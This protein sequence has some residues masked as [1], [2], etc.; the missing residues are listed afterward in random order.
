[1]KEKL[2]QLKEAVYTPV[3][4][5]DCEGWRTAE[6]VP[7]TERMTGEHIKP[8]LGES[9][10]KLWDCAWMHFTGKA[11][12]SAKGE[13]LVFMIDIGGEGCLFDETGTPVR[14]ITNVT[15]EFS[16]ELGEPGKRIVQFKNPADGG[17]TADIWIEA[18]CNDLFG[19]YN[20]SGTIINKHIAVCRDD[21][22]DLYYDLDF[23]INFVENTAD[24]TRKEEAISCINA[25]F[26]ALDGEY[27][28]DSVKSARELTLAEL[29]KKNDEAL[30]VS[31]VGH[32]HMDLAWL[33]PIRETKRKCGR[34]FSTVLELMD[35]YPDYVFGI[36]Q[37][38][39]LKW[40]KEK[41]PVL[42]EKIKQ[43]A[44]EGRI[45]L[46]GGFWVECDANLTGAEA[47]VRQIIHGKRF[48]QE[49][50]GVKQEMLWLPDVFG[51]SAQIPQIMKKSGLKYFQTIKM[52]WNRVN[53]IPYHTFNWRSIDGS[54]VLV[55]MPPEGTY[56]SPASPWSLLKS[57][58]CFAEKAVSNDVLV[59]F[60]IGD[61][62]GGPGPDHLERVERAKD[63]R[64]LPKVHQAPAVDFFHKIDDSRDKY[65][66]W[67]GELYLEKHQGTY[68]TQSRN[69]RYN[70][71]MEQTL[72]DAEMLCA[73]ASRMGDFEYPKADFDRIWEEVMLYQFHDIIPGSSIKRVYDESV[74]RYKVLYEETR[75]IMALALAELEKHSAGSGYFNTL[76]CN[77]EELID[78]VKYTAAPFAFAAAETADGQVFAD[79]NTLENEYIKVVFGDGGEIKSVYDKELGREALRDVGNRLTVYEDDADAWEVPDDFAKNKS[80]RLQLADKK[81]VVSAGE[82]KLCFIYRHGDSVI[83]QDVIL[84]AGSRRLDFV[85]SADWQETHRMLRS[86]FPLTVVSNTA[87]CEIQFGNVKRPTHTN[88]SWEQAKIEVCA[89]KWVDISQRDYGVALL[90]NCKYGYRV[91]NNTIDINLLRSSTYPGEEADRGEHEFTYSLMIHPGDYYAG[92]VIDEAYRLNIPLR[93]SAAETVKPS[94]SL[95]S[96]SNGDIVVEAVKQSENGR[97]I[98][99]RLYESAGAASDFS[100]KIADAL[101]VSRVYS[102]DL[103]EE[104]LTELASHG[105]EVKLSAGPFEII[106]L[107]LE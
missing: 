75:K 10:G 87:D 102:S 52:S 24:E 36:S 5:L 105:G 11:P 14:G 97:G 7:Y 68:T 25:A 20:G 98:T 31:A 29:A 99:L 100:L 96:V 40:V 107:V 35:R 86:S 60:G 15:S 38:Q 69:K 30:S 19:H 78:G 76:S 32:A 67:V 45:E 80:E 57:Q 85:T 49:E 46:Q 103:C 34:T 16:R 88:T 33:W 43:K 21:L 70:R 66:T 83:K 94:D 74:A 77:R 59:L 47:L 44:A 54:E 6:P 27:S 12:E 17:D 81:L 2:K 64:G 56:N 23:L 50:F 73:F 82:S 95:L 41:Y 9:W 93:G 4:E 84:R 53:K 104:E 71:L 61:G 91:W 26:D 22:R 3:A 13:H 92:G 58:D 72:R 51:Y 90:N 37:P 39:Q 63:Y 79:E 89:H 65:P 8:A 101:K 18:G 55:H 42:Y 48:W 28:A 106:T 1:M 62:G